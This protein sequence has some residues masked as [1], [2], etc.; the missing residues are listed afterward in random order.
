MPNRPIFIVGT[1]RSGTTL[2]RSLLSAHS[3]IAV[4]PETHFLKRA[5]L[6]GMPS[7]SPPDFASFWDAYKG[8]SRFTNL[9]LDAGEC[10]H[11][12]EAAGDTSFRAIF[13]TVLKL[14]RRKKRGKPRV[15]EKNAGPLRLSG[16]HLGLVPRCARDRRA[17]RSAGRDRFAAEDPLGRR[18]DVRQLQRAGAVWRNGARKMVSY[19]AK[20]WRRVYERH[21]GPWM[22][23]ERVMLTAYEDLVGDPRGE[24]KRICSFLDEE[25]EEAMI[26]QKQGT[27][28][29]EARS[30][31]DGQWTQWRAPAQC[32]D[33]R[34]N[35]CAV[36]GEM[37]RGT[38][39][40]GSRDDRRSLRR[41][42]EECRIFLYPVRR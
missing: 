36:A 4:T 21:T 5:F 12:I 31:S 32:A 26:E 37:A 1:G 42:H 15:G 29:H 24:V 25:F 14:L 17:P 33:T 20:D 7:S 40:E 30:E 38:D 18:R 9:G 34:R 39:K 27:Q 13:G 35:N 23:D 19:Y 2:V 28:S 22:S 16:R 6:W 8:W 41:G 3:R 10:R 11:R